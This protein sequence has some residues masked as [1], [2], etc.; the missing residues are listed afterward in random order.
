MLAGLCDFHTNISFFPMA[1]QTLALRLSAFLAIF[2]HL[3]PL[4][5]SSRWLLE[6]FHVGL[7]GAVPNPLTTL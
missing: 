7:K 2:A 3:L 4:K 5:N 6:I 1:G